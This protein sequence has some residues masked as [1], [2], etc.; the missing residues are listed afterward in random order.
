M[1][2][3]LRDELKARKTAG[4]VNLI[5]RKDKI[6]SSSRQSTPSVS[7]MP[8]SSE[9]TTQVTEPVS[10]NPFGGTICTAEHLNSAEATDWVTPSIQ[11]SDPLIQNQA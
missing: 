9:G 11:V 2:K 6:V 7:A 1:A 10:I 5:I 3:R 4:E 8:G